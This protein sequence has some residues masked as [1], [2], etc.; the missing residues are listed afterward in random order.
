MLCAQADGV[1]VSGSYVYVAGRVSN[2]LVVID[3]SN[4]ASPVIRGS[5][6]SSSL[7]NGVREAG[8]RERDWPRAL[9]GAALAS[10]PPIM[11]ASAAPPPAD[12]LSRSRTRSHVLCAQATC[13]AVSGSYAYVSAMSSYSLVVVDISNPASPVIRGSVVSSNLLN[14]VGMA[15]SCVHL[16]RDRG[17]TA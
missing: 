9:S 3:I 8:S 14:G 2:S 1:A 7:L 5:V 11:L 6:V 16:A 4:P 15:L 13:V 12:A 10:V 17:A